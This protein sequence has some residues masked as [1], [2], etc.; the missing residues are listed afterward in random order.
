MIPQSVL[1]A[2][3]SIEKALL[4]AVL[5]LGTVLVLLAV[6]RP[7]KREHD[8]EMVLS[9]PREMVLLALIVGA[10]VFIRTVGYARFLTAPSPF[11]ALTP[12]V[13]GKMLDAGTLWQ[14]WVGLLRNFQ[15]GSVETSVTALPVAATFQALLG[16]A[17]HL[18]TLIGAFYGVAAVVLAWALG[19]A[20]V[21]P[22][23]GLVF[24]FVLAASPLQIVWA[25]L[26]G[27]HITGVTH[28]LLTLW[29][30]YLAGKRRSWVLAVLT[31]VVV[32]CSVYQYAAA[33]VAIPLGF[34]MLVAGLWRSHRSLLRSLSVLLVA[35]LTVGLLY[36][37]S[38]PPNVRA[39]WPMYPGYT[40]N[41][42][43]RTAR[44][45]VSQHADE[46]LRHMPAALRSYFVADRAQWESPTTP[47]WGMQ[48]GGLCL[49]PV[50]LLGFLG[51]IHALW[52]PGRGW[53]WLLL[54]VL[55]FAVPV[56]SFPTARRFLILDLAWCALAAD[57]FLLLLRSRLARRLSEPLA[58][59]V[60]VLVLVSMATWSFATVLVLNGVLPPRHGQLIPFGESGFGDG[61][62]CFRCLQAANEW[63]DEIAQQ[64]LVVLF[65]TDLE[66]ENF[67]CPGGLA[68][69]GRVA[70]LS[71]GRP[72]N[73]VEFYPV[74][75]NHSET[76]PW[77]SRYFDPSTTD[78]PSYLIGL[79]E[80]ARPATIVWHFERP[81]QWER[82]LAEQLVNAGGQITEF[83]SPLSATPAIQVRTEWSRRREVFRLLLQLRGREQGC[84][85]LE[86]T[87]HAR[88]PFPVLHIAASTAVSE[89]TAPEWIVGS[90]HTVA[91]RTWSF[92]DDW[93]IGSS[94]DAS[95]FHV[96][97]P[98]GTDRVHD[99]TSGTKKDVQAVSTQEPHGLDCATRI[100]SHWWVLDPTTGRLTTSDP[101]GA[102]V[103][104][105]RWVGIARDGADHLVLASADQLI[106]VF[107]VA[108]RTELLR[109][110][111]VVPPSRRA[112]T[113]ECSPV[114]AGDGWY[115]T[116]NHLTSLLTVYDGMGGEVG[117]RDLGKLLGL[118]EGNNWISA[119]AANG[120]YLSVGY[121]DQVVTVK[122]SHLAECRDQ[123]A[124][125]SGG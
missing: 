86:T 34:A 31:G 80:A 59:G 105:G 61:M 103:P 1:A 3:A 35:S 30:G 16:P 4:V 50:A 8:G 106:A 27:I 22:A 87:G 60:A 2:S 46:W 43:E 78:A 38:R 113:N 5:A 26:G 10:A 28:V 51:L 42:G 94:A 125:A 68:I 108:T 33:R 54:A 73:F 116:F 115:A 119:V 93:P 52:R 76:I 23:F 82:W 32:W 44:D 6:V 112:V 95:S 7:A 49:A 62:T 100:G 36:L 57:G 53:P 47:R 97:S 12:P 63:Q 117:T 48:S 123:R 72:E 24:A 71:A 41:T 121:V 92:D 25:R 74:M 118:G 70:A 14:Y 124:A 122:L 75:K 21:S 15:D 88:Y 9:R 77:V 45:L 19:R 91:F 110:P 99:L 102:W 64:R 66:R 29:C 18:P 69:Y 84:P 81:T 107:D 11:S 20:V 96:L 83:Q 55:G 17:L 98:R 13:V 65:D 37:V 67:T 89:G 58:A 104:S 40:G 111:A 120:P 101:R 109:F 56:L 39:L 85:V 79:L 90:W 114:V